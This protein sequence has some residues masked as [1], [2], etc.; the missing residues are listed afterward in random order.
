MAA[1]KI[2]VTPRTIYPR[3][4]RKRTVYD[5]EGMVDGI[6]Y[7][8]TGASRKEAIT[9]ARANVEFCR[10]NPPLTALG[11]RLEANGVES[12]CLVFPHKGASMFSAASMQEALAKLAADYHDHPEIPEFI[13]AVTPEAKS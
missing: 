3:F 2:E 9:L 11:Y 10:Q 13:R 12:F 5:A 6:P 1:V 4:G 8:V 7:Y